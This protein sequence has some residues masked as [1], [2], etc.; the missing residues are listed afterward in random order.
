[1]KLSD[2]PTAAT[3]GMRLEPLVLDAQPELRADGFRQA[4]VRTLQA[5]SRIGCAPRAAGHLVVQEVER[6]VQPRV[7]A[8]TRLADH[9]PNLFPT[10]AVWSCPGD[11]RTCRTRSASD[12]AALRPG[13]RS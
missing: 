13:R 4:P 8:C 12:A 3:A 6:L 1:M 2:F 5:L 10:A 9:G 7:V 11:R